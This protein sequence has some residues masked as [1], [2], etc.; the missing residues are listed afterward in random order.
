M[1]L[2]IAAAANDG[3]NATSPCRGRWVRMTL[4]DFTMRS[5]G[6]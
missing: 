5:C 6:S 3:T 4:R 1:A 2:R